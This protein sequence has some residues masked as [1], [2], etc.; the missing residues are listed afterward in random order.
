MS[1]SRRKTAAR[2]N[3]RREAVQ[4]RKTTTWGRGVTHC[5]AYC[6]ATCSSYIQ[7]ISRPNPY[8]LRSVRVSMQTGGWNIKPGPFPATP[9]PTPTRHNP[10]ST[11]RHTQV[12]TG[13]RAPAADG[14]IGGRAARGGRGESGTT[15]G[16]GVTR[17]R[18]YCFATGQSYTMPY[19]IP[20]LQC[21]V[22]AIDWARR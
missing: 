20:N 7:P 9:R 2:G 11:K 10:N 8:L 3:G 15:Q 19:P 4:A 1:A 22:R 17:C 21:L 12:E 16:R 14:Q 18:A 6:F 13:K 5:R